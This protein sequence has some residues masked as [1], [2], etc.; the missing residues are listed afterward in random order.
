M[1]FTRE[2]FLTILSDVNSSGK[3]LKKII[4]APH[5]DMRPFLMEMA[6][7]RYDGR[8]LGIEVIQDWIPK[9]YDYEIYYEDRAQCLIDKP[10]LEDQ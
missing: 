8:F 6:E 2:L 1:T 4:I 9:G 10:K 7:G 5:L 3:W